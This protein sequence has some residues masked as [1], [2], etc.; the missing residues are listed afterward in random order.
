MKDATRAFPGITPITEGNRVMLARAAPLAN[1]VERAISLVDF[2]I[3]MRF[4]IT[5][6]ACALVS[7]K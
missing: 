1:V 5:S 2:S 6:L 4:R 7:N 3:F